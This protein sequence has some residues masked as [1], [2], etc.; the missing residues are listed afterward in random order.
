MQENSKNK[1]RE[2]RDL[3]FDISLKDK[4]EKKWWQLA[5]IISWVAT[6]LLII[7][8]IVILPL[9]TIIPYIVKVNKL[10]KPTPVRLLT[11]KYNPSAAAKEYFT[12]KWVRLAFNVYR[13][14]NE[15]R[16]LIKAYGFLT[17]SG[18]NVFKR[19]IKSKNS[20][21]TFRANHP[22][23]ERI[24]RVQGVNFI[25]PTVL[26]VRT[27]LNIINPVGKMAEQK[28]VNF[29]IHIKI[30]PPSSSFIILKNPLGIYIRSFTINKQVS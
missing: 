12:V 8:F 4:L 30:I 16:Q 9:K 13:G 15:K 6:L 7:G 2:A 19:Y 10:G 24:Y 17:S 27:L 3:Y 5:A 11:V 20:S 25:S 26:Q 29:I 21:L 28:Y 22:H 1:Y 23:R 14:V 18:Q